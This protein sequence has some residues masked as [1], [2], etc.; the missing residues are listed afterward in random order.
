MAGRCGLE[1]HVR[2]RVRCRLGKRADS[3]NAAELG[4]RL[5]LPV[6]NEV[7]LARGLAAAER[8]RYAS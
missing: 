5:S 6:P 7:T 4:A 1:D 3:S 8:S 2:R